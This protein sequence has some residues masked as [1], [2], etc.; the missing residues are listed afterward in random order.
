M[1]DIADR[2]HHVYRYYNAEGHPLYI[3]CTS[4][5][6]QRESA[7]KSKP[8]FGQVV[9]REVETYPD[10]ESGRAAEGA[11]IRRERPIHNTQLAV[12]YIGTW[13]ISR[14]GYR[15]L[16]AARKRYFENKSRIDGDAAS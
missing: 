6:P 8:W 5:L 10:R 16:I 9:R 3:G 2:P 14:S 7:H 1:T 12:D 4:N 13:P 15:R 11:A